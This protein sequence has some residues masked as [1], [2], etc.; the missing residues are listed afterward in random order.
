M[1][2]A[3]VCIAQQGRGAAAML[4]VVVHD[5][6]CV[7]ATRSRRRT[8]INALAVDTGLVLGAAIVAAAADGT[9][10]VVTHLPAAA[11]VISPAQGLADASDC[12][13]LLVA[14]AASTRRADRPAHTVLAHGTAR[15]LT[16]L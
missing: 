13:A 6:A 5:A 4:L 14:E 8:Q 2:T 15:T 7:G 3:D 1:V 10:Q 12:V 16:V 11:V 9:H